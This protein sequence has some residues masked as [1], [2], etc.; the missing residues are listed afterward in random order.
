MKKF[1]AVVAVLLTAICATAQET[2]TFRFG[3]VSYQQV[4]VAMPEYAQMESDLDTLRQ[5]YDAELKAAEEEFNSKYATFL[6]EYSSYAPAILRKRQ[7]ELEDLMRRN[8]Q[9][10][11]ESR[12]LLRQASDEMLAP[13]KAKLDEAIRQIA[14]QYSLAFVLNVDSD[15]VPFMNMNMA[16]NITAAVEEAV[17]K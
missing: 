16:Y 17:K 11:A 3:C 6:D 14:T 9:F 8:E 5:Q 1:I 7:S 13:I 10:S 12:R 15:A 2:V 4:L